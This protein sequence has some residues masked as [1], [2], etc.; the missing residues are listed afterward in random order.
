M[1]QDNP[2]V[3]DLIDLAEAHDEQS[4]APFIPTTLEENMTVIREFSEKYSNINDEIISIVDQKLV[5][6]GKSLDYYH[7]SFI[8]LYQVLSMST[9]T[10][11]SEV[12][13]LTYAMICSLCRHIANIIDSQNSP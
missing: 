12:A 11:E 1:Q 5:H 13:V 2:T 10:E 8:T 4:I 7:G 6:K 9:Q 3:D